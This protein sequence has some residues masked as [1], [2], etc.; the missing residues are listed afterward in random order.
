MASSYCIALKT[1]MAPLKLVFIRHAESTGNLQR[2]MQGHGAFELSPQG[3]RQVDQLIQRLMVEFEPPTHFYASPLRRAAQTAEA[4]ATALGTSFNLGSDSLPIQWTEAIAE[5]QTGIFEGL[6]WAE[7]K[8]RYPDLCN[9]LEQTTEWIPIPNAESL[10]DGRDRA[11]SFIRTLLERHQP[12]DR[13]WIV[14]HS[15]ILQQLVSVLLGSD[16]TW[17]FEVGYTALFEFWL[18]PG[19][20]ACGDQNRWN[21]ELWKIWRFNDQAHLATR[22]EAPRS[23]EG[24]HRDDSRAC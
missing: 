8:Q 23:T 13:L 20:W 17:G 2:K 7:A 19:Y 22:R 12:G 16:R 21:T 6:T 4:I 24:E 15:W 11:Q 14:T 18:E 10:Q 9:R 5:F 1:A 3:W